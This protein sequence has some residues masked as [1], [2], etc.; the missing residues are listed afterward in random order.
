MR[1][2]DVGTPNLPE[3]I[4][5]ILSQTEGVNKAALI[6]DAHY[7]DGGYEDEEGR[8]I[9][10]SRGEADHIFRDNILKFTGDKELAFAYHKAIRKT[11]AYGWWRAKLRRWWK[12]IKFF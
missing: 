5:I 4:R 7:R 12:A 11:G 9:K 2:Y 3:W 8:F 10:L 1:T 6:H